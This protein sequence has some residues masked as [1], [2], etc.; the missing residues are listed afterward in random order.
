MTLANYKELL[1][2]NYK[3]LFENNAINRKKREIL[4]SEYDDEVLL[5]AM[6]D[7]YNLIKLLLDTD[8]CGES[9]ISSPVENVEVINIELNDSIGDY[10]DRLFLLNGC[11]LIS[12]LLLKYYLGEKLYIGIRE[13]EV[14]REDYDGIIE[15]AYYTTLEIYNIPTDTQKL[16]ESVFGI[17]LKKSE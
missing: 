10:A 5:K 17:S 16:K 4:L 8:L 15:A 2:N 1:I 14:Y 3:Y 7:T 13:N 12:E 11:I 6:S 9:H